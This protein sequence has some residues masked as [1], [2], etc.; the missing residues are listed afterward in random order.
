MQQM[1]QRSFPEKVVFLGGFSLD[2]MIDCQVRVL[3]YKNSSIFLSRLL[4]PP[5]RQPKINAA[6]YD[7]TCAK[8]NQPTQF[9]CDETSCGESLTHKLMILSLLAARSHAGAQKFEVL[10]QGSRQGWPKERP[11]ERLKEK[12][13]HHR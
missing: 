8:I 5:W 10:G 2:Q 6:N 13:R 1:L 3:E 12:L 4:G 9:P 11:K 7:P